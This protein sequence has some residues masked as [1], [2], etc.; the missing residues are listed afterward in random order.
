MADTSN[1]LSI[2][3]IRLPQS[4]EFTLEAASSLYSNFVQ[5]TS[6]SFFDKLLSRKKTILSLEV[7]LKDGQIHFYIVTPEK[8]LEFFRSQILAQYPSAI[9]KA[10]SDY[11]SGIESPLISQL[12]LAKSY[13]YPIKSA[14]DFRDTDPLA[15]VLAPLSRSNRPDD[16][17][18]YQILLSPAPKN[19]QGSITSTIQNG[20][21][22][23][24]EKNFRQAH[25][26]KQ[27]F[28]N[29]IQFPGLLTQINL[30]SNNPGLIT[31]VASSFGTYTSPRGNFIK[32]VTP[33]LFTKKKLLKSILTRD[34]ASLNTQ[35]LNT[36]ELSVLWHFPSKFTRLP[37]IAWGQ[38]LF[39]DPPENLPVADGLSDE[40]KQK[41]T[42]FAKTEYRNKDSIYGIREGEDRRR[43]TYIIGKSGTGKTTL[44]A[45]M[46][47]D[48]IRKGR[49]VAII[50]PHGDLCNTI[51]DYVPKSRHN[52]CVYFNP[53]DPEYVYPL[54]V[55]EAQNDSQRELVASGVL[56][57]FKKLY[58][59]VSWGPRL[60]H[61]LRNAVLTLVN[62]PGSNMV[63]IVD[64]LTNKD[65]R[66]KVVSELQNPTLKNFWLNE[67][68]RMDAKF[69]A[70]SVSPILNKVGQFIASTNIR[71]TLNHPVSKVRI[72]DIMDQKKI[73]IADLSTGKLG[74]DN[75]ALLGALLITQI[76]LSAMNRV[77]Q[78]QEDRSDFYLYV[79]EFQ[80]FATESFIKILSEARKF[81]L[82]L[83][84][85]NQYMSQ[86][87]RPI[88]DAILGNVGSIISFV[89][90]NQDAFILSKEFGQTNFPPEDL[91][92]LGKY[93]I[94][95]KLS[96]DSE[97]T[98]PFYATTLPPL[99]CKNQGRESLIKNSQQ[100][101]GKK[102]N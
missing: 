15:S 93:Q 27:V 12:T 41:I 30:L 54:N 87:D 80:N 83:I 23:D 18:L 75:S 99:A 39:A 66:Q 79:D 67:F 78:N 32:E 68:D 40:E 8:N 47:I 31:S 43:H 22:V 21:L 48:D 94:I 38:N 81:K 57:I 70:E 69:Q 96:I 20:I 26:D 88:H 36:D 62:T 98:S 52:D 90:G 63:N 33:G 59:N 86:L 42:F 89:V 24:K 58:G 17:F 7:L 92:Q 76:Q 100:R 29:K 73:L 45:N 19:W 50:D 61:I 3:E 16:F 11:L 9:T 102:I 28:E 46:A 37:N 60:E 34:F 91:V 72:Q 101:W 56:S 97:T 65:Y 25:P 5:G 4:N 2:L 55:L 53:S 71:N 44:I 85:A 74:E 49:G 10:T 6:L 82:N 13:A 77:F 64:I 14:R 35:I 51:L 95:N 84:I 1:P